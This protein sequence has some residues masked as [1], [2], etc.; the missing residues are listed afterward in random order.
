MA[1]ENPV[2][3]EPKSGLCNLAEAMVASTLFRELSDKVAESLTNKDSEGEVSETF[4]NAGA[5]V[6][7]SLAIIANG[8]DEKI[9]R[10]LALAEKSALDAEKWE[11]EK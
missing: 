1:N 5:Y 11:D 2:I 10:R 6:I 9:A 8:L 3:V 4:Y 7:E